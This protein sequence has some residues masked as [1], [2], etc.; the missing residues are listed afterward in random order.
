MQIPNHW[1]RENEHGH[2]DENVREEDPPVEGGLIHAMSARSM[3]VSG[4][5]DGCALE[6]RGQDG[7]ESVAN[8]DEHEGVSCIP[9]GF[10]DED[11]QVEEQ[12]RHLDQDNVD[13]AEPSN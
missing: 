3:L 6:G 12:D 13:T 5:R 7:A 1:H 8:G 4:I 2:V 10:S 11:A 9:V